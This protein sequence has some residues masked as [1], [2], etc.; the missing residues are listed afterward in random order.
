[1]TFGERLEF[2]ILS[3]EISRQNL[4]ED[5][6]I[7]PSTLSC[8]IKNKRQPAYDTLLNL[9]GYFDTTTDFLLGN[10]QV[11]FPLQ[12]NFSDEELILIE[13]YRHL[14]PYEQGVL[15][16]QAKLL[17]RTAKERKKK[18]TDTSKKA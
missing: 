14:P 15:I 10:T 6:H 12:K 16:S 13:M 2:L 3:K 17:T 9:A 5:L 11:R 18:S 8:Y 4:S 7:S 1:M